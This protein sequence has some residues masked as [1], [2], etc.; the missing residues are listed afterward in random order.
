MRKFW[1][2]QDHKPNTFMMK[3][4]IVFRC[5]NGNT[6]TCLCW[7]ANPKT[8]AEGKTL[9]LSNAEIM[10]RTI[11]IGRNPNKINWSDKNIDAF[12]QS[13]GKLNER[14]LV[15]T[16]Y[17]KELSVLISIIFFY[18]LLLLDQWSG[19]SFTTKWSN[20]QEGPQLEYKSIK[21][22]IFWG[23]KL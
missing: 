1:W 19:W 17:L 22:I 7:S 5:I 2:I 10:C 4:T 18:F 3:E 12:L 16:G 11:G 21:S 6:C 14:M 20:I 13:V 8:C 15:L 9:L 23:H